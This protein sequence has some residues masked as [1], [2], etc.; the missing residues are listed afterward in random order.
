L[1][2]LTTE[3]VGILLEVFLGFSIGIIISFIFSW[4]I[5]LVC[6]ACAPFVF[7]GGVVTSK[8]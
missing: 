7:V 1:N 5:S 3:T 4:K 6:I 2:G 8:L